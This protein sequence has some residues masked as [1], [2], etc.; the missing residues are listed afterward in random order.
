MSPRP[1]RSPEGSSQREGL[2]PCPR[3]QEP[4]CPPTARHRGRRG[5]AK[6]H[7]QAGAD[8]SQKTVHKAR[9]ACPPGGLPGGGGE[10]TWESGRVPGPQELSSP[11]GF[12]AGRV[13]FRRVWRVIMGR[14]PQ[15]LGEATAAEREWSKRA[16]MEGGS[17]AAGEASPLVH[18]LGVRTHLPAAVYWALA[19]LHMAQPWASQQTGRGASPPLHAEEA[20]LLLG[21]H[22]SPGLPHRW[23]AWVQ[24]A[25]W[26]SLEMREQHPLARPHT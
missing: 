10:R 15:G 13:P 7:T 23:A 26:P 24:S 14:H 25:G 22:G 4:V 20:S 5:K 1:H 18:C 17:G 16:G 12:R 2:H 6:P 11:G 8:R 21:G 9:R 19:R 3:P